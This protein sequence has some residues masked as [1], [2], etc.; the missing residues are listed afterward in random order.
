MRRDNYRFQVHPTDSRVQA[1]YHNFLAEMTDNDLAGKLRDK[2]ARS[3]EKHYIEHMATACATPEGRTRL[4]GWLET[5][6]PDPA[7]RAEIKTM[8][9]GH[10]IQI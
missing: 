2:F 9:R 10:G 3:I 6:V 7:L 4:R 1:V 8:I 5:N